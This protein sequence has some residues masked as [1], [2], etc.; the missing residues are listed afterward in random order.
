MCTDYPFQV[1][2]SKVWVPRQLPFF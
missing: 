1:H 2:A